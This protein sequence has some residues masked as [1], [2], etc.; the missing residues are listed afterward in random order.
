[1]KMSDTFKAKCSWYDTICSFPEEYQFELLKNIFILARGE[2]PKFSNSTTEMLFEFIK[3]DFQ[4]E[5]NKRE[6]LSE[7]RKQAASQRWKNDKSK[8]NNV[9]Q[10]NEQLELFENQEQKEDTNVL[11]NYYNS[12]T[13]KGKESKE[14]EIEKENEENTIKE[15]SRTRFSPPSVEEVNDYI[16]SKGYNFSAENFCDFY[17]SKGWFVGSNKMKDWKAAVRT[18]ARRHQP[19][20]EP[21]DND[22]R[23][24]PDLLWEQR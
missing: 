22:V 21:T 1:M 12:N 23:L 15:K 13:I 17:E 7:K 4:D 11:E 24:H 16:M 6:E 14:K 3:R 19:S 20:N 8:K 9:S 10:K 2:A 5:E 18:W